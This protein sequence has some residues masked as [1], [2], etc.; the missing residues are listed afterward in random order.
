MAI[1]LHGT[2][3]SPWV[4]LAAAVL[5]EKEV[6]FELVV[7][8]MAN[9][10]HKSPEYLSKQPFGQV[11][12]LD[13]DGFILY[14]SKA[15]AHYV[16]RKYQNQGTPL[17][18]VEPKAEALYQQAVF[19]GESHFF[20]HV[21]QAGKEIFKPYQGLTPDQA[22]ID[23]HVADLSV[24]LD[25]YEEILSKRKYLLGDE[26]SLV[27]FYHIP[28]LYVLSLSGSEILES[29]PNVAKWSKDISSRVSWT[30]TAQ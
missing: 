5:K 20:S 8:D 3:G 21:G 9:R 29:K 23:K 27:D 4:R 16:A 10:E 28:G 11:P 26:I 19:V 6:P 17:L 12:Y 24:K 1:K 18:P 30:S 15:I 13:D 14:E 2:Y 7:V 25:V 22:A